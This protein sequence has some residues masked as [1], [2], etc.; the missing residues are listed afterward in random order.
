MIYKTKDFKPGT[1]NCI[2]VDEDKYYHS[3][4]RDNKVVQVMK[5]TKS[6]HLDLENWIDKVDDNVKIMVEN[7]VLF[8]EAKS[9]L[10]GN[11]RNIIISIDNDKVVKTY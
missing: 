3:M 6:R 8:I 1:Y 11:K 10:M 5:N 7:W 9:L 2:Y 4:I